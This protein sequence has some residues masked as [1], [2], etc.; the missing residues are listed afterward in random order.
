MFKKVFT[1]VSVTIKLVFFSGCFFN[2]LYTNDPFWN[3]VTGYFTDSTRT[4]QELIY[5]VSREAIQTMVP[6]PYMD[7]AKEIRDLFADMK[8]D[9]NYEVRKYG[10]TIEVNYNPQM[11]V[12]SGPT[13]IIKKTDTS[14]K[15]TDVYFGK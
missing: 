12:A 13:F 15:L 10:D 3:Q 8:D 6:Q 4:S 7:T 11:E 9:H 2:D 14:W 5:R 1:F